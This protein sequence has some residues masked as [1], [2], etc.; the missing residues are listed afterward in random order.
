MGIGTKGG[1]GVSIVGERIDQMDEFKCLGSIM[2][3]KGGTD[4]GIQ[5][6]IGRVR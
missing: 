3:K 6:H 5:E 1:D 2:S 4:E